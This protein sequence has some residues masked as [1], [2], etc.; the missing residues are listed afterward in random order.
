MPFFQKF[1]LTLASEISDGLKVLWILRE[2]D[3]KKLQLKASP[4][5]VHKRS[6]SVILRYLPLRKEMKNDALFE[7]GDI[8]DVSYQWFV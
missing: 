3:G 1:I 6:S 2:N 8:K 7:K 5:V 4:K